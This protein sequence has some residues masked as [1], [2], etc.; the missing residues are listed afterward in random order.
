MATSNKDL[1][2]IEPSGANLLRDGASRS[3]DKV[4]DLSSWMTASVDRP[5]SPALENIDESRSQYLGRLRRVKE[6]HRVCQ[7]LGQIDF[8][9]RGR[10]QSRAL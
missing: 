1:D 3:W 5:L 2:R 6:F 10:R 7:Q 8:E 9:S 4:P